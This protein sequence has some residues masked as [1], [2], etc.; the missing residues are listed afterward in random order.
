VVLM[1]IF[2]CVTPASARRSLDLSVII[3]IGAALGLSEALSHSGLA[4]VVASH[5]MNGFG[6]GAWTQLL[7]LYLLT[8]VLTQLLTNNAAAV[9]VFPLA[10]SV[11]T[12]TGQDPRPLFIVVA[13]AASASFLTP[14]GYQTNLMVMG[15]GGYRFVDYLKLGFPVTLIHAVL[16]LTLVP[17]LY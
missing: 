15:P 8:L 5:W 9:L 12:A 13:L 6:S 16:T 1:F 7:G 17:L 2:G 3:S 11:A 14:I 4:G 10:L